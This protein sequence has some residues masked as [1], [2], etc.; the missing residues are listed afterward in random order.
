MLTPWLLGWALAAAAPPPNFASQQLPEYVRLAEVAKPLTFLG[1]ATLE[2]KMLFWYG[3][4]LYGSNRPVS[5]FAGA[6]ETC[7]LQIVWLADSASAQEVQ[8]HFRALLISQ[9]DAQSYARLQPRLERFLTALPAVQRGQQWNLVYVP[10][11]GMRFY[12]D[13]LQLATV[14]GVEVNRAVLGMWLGMQA[15]PL[16]RSKLLSNLQ[17]TP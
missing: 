8:E 12:A 3:V 13:G 1:S 15:D 14:S 11:A 7:Q 6:L 5:D 4:A 10:D 17:A 9:L 16:V 2:R